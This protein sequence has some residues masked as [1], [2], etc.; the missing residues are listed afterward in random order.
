M[1]VESSQLS[2]EFLF[3]LSRAAENG[4]SA[5]LKGYLRQCEFP[6]MALGKPLTAFVVAC[7]EKVPLAQRHA[8]TISPQAFLENPDQI[9]V[10]K[11]AIIE[12]GAFVAGPTYIAANATVR[13]GAYVRGSVYVGAGAVVGH[14]TEV[15]GSLLLPKAKAA[16]FAYVGDSILGVDTNLGAGTKLANMRFDHGLVSIRL[17]AQVFETGLKKMGAIFG[18]FAQSGCNSVTN[19]GTILLPRGMILPTTT[20]RGVI[21]PGLLSR[22]QQPRNNLIDR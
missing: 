21:I 1:S 2:S 15:K 9:V 4:L 3:E 11:G 22:T 19:P 5:D 10:E 17:G 8:G 18:N 13:H 12:A 16:H 7:I 6:W 14:T 20:G